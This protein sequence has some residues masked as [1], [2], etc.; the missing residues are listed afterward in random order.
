MTLRVGLSIY[1]IDTYYQAHSFYLSLEV[2]DGEI[3][4]DELEEYDEEE[5]RLANEAAEENEREEEEGK[6]PDEGTK[7]PN[8]EEDVFASITEGV[9][10]KTEDIDM[11]KK[12]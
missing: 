4:V 12:V 8:E 5:Y 7:K 3:D 10:I 11:D 1:C 6:K 9:K 2:S